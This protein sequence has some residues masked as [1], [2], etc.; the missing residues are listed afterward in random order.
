MNGPVSSAIDR[1]TVRLVAIK[2]SIKTHTFNQDPMILTDVPL[3]LLESYNRLE[4]PP[5]GFTNFKST[6]AFAMP[7]SSSFFTNALNSG[8]D[9]WAKNPA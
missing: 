3:N 8:D 6:F 7:A 5:A 2:I 1:E 9:P 4:N